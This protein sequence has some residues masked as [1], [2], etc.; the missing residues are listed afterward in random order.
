M[1]TKS[2][3]TIPNNFVIVFWIILI[4]ATLTWFLPGGEYVKAADGTVTFNQ[5]ESVPQTYQI[6]TSFFA[7]F[8]K[9][10]GIII[11][12]LVVGGA[13]WV[14]N[15]NGAIDVGIYSFLRRSKG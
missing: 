3:F 11:F 6:F 7:G 15:S 13:F 2:K 4:C 8:E 12:I 14:V 10:A 1:G 9:G 5:V